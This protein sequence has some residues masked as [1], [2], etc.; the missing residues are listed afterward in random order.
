MKCSKCGKEIPIDTKPSDNWQYYC[1]DCGLA[2]ALKEIL[3]E[4]NEAKEYYDRNKNT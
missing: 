4:I 3:N 1:A 2:E